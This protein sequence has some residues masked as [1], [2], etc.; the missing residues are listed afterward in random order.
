[1]RPYLGGWLSIPI[2]FTDGKPI[3]GSR[4]SPSRCV[5]CTCGGLLGCTLFLPRATGGRRR[6]IRITTLG[7][8]LS[9]YL[10]SARQKPVN[11]QCPSRHHLCARI[12]FG[13]WG[14]YELGCCRLSSLHWSFRLF[15]RYVD[16]P[17]P[18]QKF[19]WFF[20]HRCKVFYGNISRS[21]VSSF[22]DH[23]GEWK[24]VG[25]PSVNVW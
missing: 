6:G 13:S 1:M 10:L 19:S 5:P 9:S 21:Q 4:R 8:L 11:S 18:R 16:S 20:P 24:E 15:N 23:Q 12:G 17:V 14:M 7:F 3:R 2:G 25:V 22:T